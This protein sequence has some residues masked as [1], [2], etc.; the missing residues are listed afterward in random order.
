M[1]KIISLGKL[2][3]RNLLFLILPLL[4]II[5]NILWPLLPSNIF[6]N[7]LILFISRILNGTFWI[8]LEKRIGTPSSLQSPTPPLSDPLNLVYNSITPEQETMPQKESKDENKSSKKGLSQRE[9]DIIKSRRKK[10]E[11]TIKHWLF[12]LLINLINFFASL[13]FSIMTRISVFNL[14]NQGLVTVPVVARV[15]FTALLSILFLNEGKPHRHQILSF[16]VITIVVVFSNIYFYDA[17]EYFF[18]QILS[19]LFPNFLFSLSYVLGNKYLLMTSGNVY[20]LLFFNGL[21]GLILLFIFEYF[22]YNISNNNCKVNIEERFF[23]K[24]ICSP[25]NINEI[26][27]IINDFKNCKSFLQIFYII[28]YL[29]ISTLEVTFVWLIIFFFSANHFAAVNSVALFYR[30]L[31]GFSK[32]GKIVGKIINVIGS[33][34]VSFMSLVYNEIVILRFCKLDINTKEEITL[35]AIEETNFIKKETSSD[36]PIMDITAGSNSNFN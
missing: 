10:I 20:K 15:I 26:K 23:L 36:D 17:D 6:I 35:R 4:T 29:I 2:S 3:I 33:I 31:E 16:I 8:A 22:L 28:S 34:L 14:N 13:S 11:K 1:K 24:Q 9:L 21:I 7:S 27:T 25:E 18:L 19:M 5:R 12:L 32:G 30:C